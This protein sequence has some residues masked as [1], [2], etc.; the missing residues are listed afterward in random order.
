MLDAYQRNRAEA[1]WSILDADPVA[2]VIRQW[3]VDQSSWEGEPAQLYEV[4]SRIAARTGMRARGW[5]ANGQ[6]LSR[7][8]NRLSSTLRPVGIVVTRERG[9]R[10]RIRITRGECECGDIASIALRRK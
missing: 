6:A 4:L 3:M 8:L 10:R 7:Q 2:S 5:P 9:A 1:R